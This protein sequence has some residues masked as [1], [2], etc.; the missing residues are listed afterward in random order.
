M[1]RK[2]SVYGCRTNYDCHNQG[3]VYAFPRDPDEREKWI[4]NLPN[5]LKVKL[6]I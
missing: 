1:V 6:N 2:C 5:Q 3:K 4:R